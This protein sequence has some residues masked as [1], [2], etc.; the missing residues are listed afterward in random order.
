[1]LMFPTTLVSMKSR[2]Q[3]GADDVQE[4]PG[5]FQNGLAVSGDDMS[6]ASFLGIRAPSRWTDTM[7]FSTP[8]DSWW[9][10]GSPAADR[11]RRCGTPVGTRRPTSSIYRMKA[12]AGRAAAAASNLDE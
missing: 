7:A 10:A 4:V 11:W 8:L 5:H 1:M 3:V 9:L 6:A 2:A 12:D